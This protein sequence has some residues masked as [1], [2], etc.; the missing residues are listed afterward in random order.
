[1]EVASEHVNDYHGERYKAIFV[2]TPLTT[3]KYI[4]AAKEILDKK[5]IDYVEETIPS[6]YV[7]HAGVNTIGLIFVKVYENSDF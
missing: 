7:A 4:S 3:E 2:N 6:L 1:M 5:K